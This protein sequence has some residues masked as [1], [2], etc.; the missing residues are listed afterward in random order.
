[1]LALEAL[2]LAI[3]QACLPIDVDTGWPAI[4]DV[5]AVEEGGQFV[6]IVKVSARLGRSEEPHNS[7]KRQ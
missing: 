3:G 4:F 6:A 2:G 7:Q 5:E 1:V